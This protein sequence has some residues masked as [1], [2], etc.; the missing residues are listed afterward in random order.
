MFSLSSV[1]FEN[2]PH[3]TLQNKQ[4][5]WNLYVKQWLLL[6]SNSHIL[7]VLH[8]I[9]YKKRRE[10][11]SSNIVLNYSFVLFCF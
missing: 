10:K 5:P 11:G 8:L 9:F 2:K 1:T 7:V 3:E 6:G 4:M